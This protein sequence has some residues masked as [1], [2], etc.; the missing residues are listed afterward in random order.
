[1]RHELFEQAMR[2][3]N[4]STS[5]ARDYL[6]QIIRRN[7]EGLLASKVSS[8]E[9]ITEV[10]KMVPT[11]Q[12]FATELT[13]FG[14]QR[15][16]Q[17]GGLASLQGHGVS[18]PI[19]FRAKA[20]DAIEEPIISHEL[21]LK[22]NVDM[23]VKATVVHN[24]AQ[25]ACTTLMGVELKT[26]HNQRTQNAHLAQLVLY[27]LMIQGDRGGSRSVIQGG[28]SLGATN[29]GV[30]LYLN[31]E[32]LS[33]VHVAPH[34]SEM[35]TL[36]GQ[37]NHVATEYAR[38]SL[39]RGV[40]L[41]YDNDGDFPNGGMPKIE[42]VD[43]APPAVL[44]ELLA[45]DHMCKKC[46]A[47]RE[48]M[49]YAA[50]ER[51]STVPGGDYDPFKTHSVLLGHFT[52]H[53]TAA[54]FSYFQEWDRLIDLEA[55]AGA[56]LA[57]ESWL[58]S[59][60]EQEKATA[61]CMSSLVFDQAESLEGVVFDEENSFGTMPVGTMSFTRSKSSSL[62]TPLFNLGFEKGCHVI[63]ST[64]STSTSPSPRRAKMHIVR[65]FLD[66]ATESQV[67]VRATKDDV[68]RIQKIAQLN[69]RQGQP[70][71]LFRLDRDNV[72][73]GVGT[74]RQNLVNLFTGDRL[75]V[76]QDDAQ[77]SVTR[78]S[79]LRDMIVRLRAPVFQQNISQSEMFRPATQNVPQIPGCDLIDL[80]CEFAELNIDQRNAVLKVW[81]ANDYTL[82]QGLP[83]TGKTSAIAFVVR[84]LAAHGKRVLIT[85]YTH[86]AVDNVVRKL[87]QKG[88]AQ[89]GVRRLL[90]A[91]VRVGRPSSS[92]PGVVPVLASEIATSLEKGQ[93]SNFQDDADS[94]ESPL[95][96][97][98]RLVMDSARI[99]GVTALTI[100]RS[101]LLLGQEFD[102]VIVDE[103]GQI[104]QPAIIGALMTTKS[105]VLVG[106]H[107]QLPPLVT[108]EAAEQG[109]YGISMLMRLADRHPSA[110]AQLTLQYRMHEDI[111]ELVNDL[112]YGGT[113]KCA[114]DGVRRQKI[115]LP[116]FLQLHYQAWLQ[117][118]VN[119]DNSVVFLDTDKVDNGEQENQD[120]NNT[121]YPQERLAGR[122]SGGSIVNDTE[123]TVVRLVVEGL[124]AAGLDPSSIGVIC[125]FRA[126]LRKMDDC[127]TLCAR[128]KDG[129]EVSTIDQ[130]QGRDKPTII[131]SFVRSNVKGRVGRLL[132]DVRRLNV[133]LSRA[134]CKLIMVGSFSTLYSGSSVLRPVLD[135]VK[136]TGRVVQ[137]S[138][139][140]D[141]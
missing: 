59:S 35:K 1:M 114:S 124:V 66:R 93:R 68:I 56:S 92:H 3:R 67:F 80:A 29:S 19:H 42:L 120:A 10:M 21:G 45:N 84:L 103:A 2:E 46:Y 127:T 48:C 138:S 99:V 108:S 125:P 47:N 14:P 107:K 12:R 79:W 69:A 23:V 100:P 91:L 4:F 133:A 121:M 28:G 122:S 55:H 63:V 97:S 106:D 132:S 7:A 64:D 95:P 5:F 76:G 70:E 85:S 44:P 90:P 18:P 37:R 128:K 94:P 112:V 137:L 135:R 109:G 72:A 77:P 65:G 32:G 52:G 75:D 140:Y 34:L 40:Q 51:S 53:L 57:A 78:L 88:L 31:A 43:P 33:A 36:I 102:V 73:T 41:V 50:S 105:F 61:K 9:A 136:K 58:K 130:F 118:A 13:A 39:P 22:G 123:A 24:Q 71:S 25:G 110:V 89:T 82:I 131:L 11:L 101:A 6:D 134:K 62:H 8:K 20:V 126:Q 113:L 49:M 141:K 104:S 26:G 119:P 15:Q 86:A 27:T 129:L 16:L 83:G 38:S 54:D 17:T 115:A 30:L 96:E 117:R 60:V 111:C 139:S 116:S 81:S 87:M 74:L 98:L